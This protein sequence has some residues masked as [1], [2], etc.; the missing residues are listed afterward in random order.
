[1]EGWRQS[2]NV[3]IRI[4]KIRTLNEPHVATMA[5]LKREGPSPHWVTGNPLGNKAKCRS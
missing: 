4:P 3:T 5:L 2:L 1:M